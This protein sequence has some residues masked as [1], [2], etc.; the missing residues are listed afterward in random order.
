[1]DQPAPKALTYFCLMAKRKCAKEKWFVE[2]EE[3]N[4]LENASIRN[5]VKEAGQGK[6]RNIPNDYV[7][8]YAKDWWKKK[9]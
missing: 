9:S 4:V 2:S 6:Q 7:R 1:M 8:P 3:I 5:Y